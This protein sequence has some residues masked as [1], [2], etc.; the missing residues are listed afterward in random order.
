MP[1]GA[2]IGVK[3]MGELDTKP[4][5]DSCK[6]KYPEDEADLKAVK[7]SSLWEEY[8]RDPEW[9]PF[10]IIKVNDGHKVISIH[11][12]HKP[13]FLVLLLF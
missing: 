13:I 4:F 5:H 2:Q 9:H 8:L 12:F 3:R 1:S 11:A 7:L 6:R 10:Q